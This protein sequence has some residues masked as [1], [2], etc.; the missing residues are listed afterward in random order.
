MKRTRKSLWMSALFALLLVG[1]STNNESDTNG[2]D[3]GSSQSSSQN[4]EESSTFPVT[5]TDASGEE[6]TLQKDPE[7]IVSLIPSNTE[8]LFAVNAGEEVIGVTEN[9]DYP[10]DVETIDHVGGMELNVEKIISLQPDLVLGHEIALQSSTEAYDQIEEAGIPVYV[11]SEATSFDEV[12]DTIETIGTLTGESQSAT[13]LI[14]KMK[15]DLTEIEE[16]AASIEEENEKRVFVESSPAPEIYAPGKGTFVNQMLEMIHANNVLSDQDG[17]V[18]VNAEAVVDY[19]PNVIMVAY[20][21][22]ENPVEAVL[23]RNGWDS[24]PAIQEEA[25]YL[26]D[27]NLLSRPGP[28][29]VEG[30]E[31]LAETIYPEI[32]SE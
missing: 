30:V 10:S 7:T 28:R 4:T 17:W 27:T 3:A 20:N 21:Y 32:Y 6:V 24:I 19:Q 11:V 9:D 13:S 23:S 25:V 29:L 18:Q 5:L 2:N 1:C 15:S 16:K 8:I 14:D 31:Q 26:I 22:T 12:Y